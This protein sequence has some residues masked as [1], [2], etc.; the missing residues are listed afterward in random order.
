MSDKPSKPTGTGE[1]IPVSAF[2][3]EERE[4]HMMVKALNDTCPENTYILICCKEMGD[5]ILTRAATAGNQSRIL[6]ALLAMVERQIR[7][8]GIVAKPEEPP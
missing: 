2:G 6:L 5:S 8:E 7:N 4:L 3:P 1:G